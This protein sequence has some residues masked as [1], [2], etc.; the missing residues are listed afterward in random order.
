MPPQGHDTVATHHQSF[1]DSHDYFR[2]P[3]DVLLKSVVHYHTPLCSQHD[4]ANAYPLFTERTKAI[5][6]YCT[7]MDEKRDQHL[8]RQSSLPDL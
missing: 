5:A 8:T 6:T 1:H 3:V 7:L 2:A 4:L